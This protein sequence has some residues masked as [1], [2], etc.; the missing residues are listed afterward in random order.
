MKTLK[1]KVISTKMAQTATVLVE[2]EKI[3]PLYRVRRRRF[4]KYQADDQL[5]VKVGDQ[6]KIAPCRPISK[7]KRWQIIEVLE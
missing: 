5:G 6:V 7:L 1:G 3:H 4:K 2:G